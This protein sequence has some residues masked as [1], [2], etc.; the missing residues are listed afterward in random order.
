MVD[1]KKAHAATEPLSTPLREKTLEAWVKLS[2]LEQRGGG[3]LSVETLDGSVFDAIVFGEKDPGQWLAGSDFFR[4]TRSFGGPAETTAAREYVQLALV[5]HADGTIAGYR[6]G[7]PYGTAYRSGPPVEF[8]PGQY[9]VLFGLRHSPA[10]GNRLLAGTILRA[11]LYDRALSSDEV[12]A[13]AGVGTVTEAELLAH[14]TMEQRAERRKHQAEASRLAAD[15]A[16]LEAALVGK[17]YAVTAVEPGPTHLLLRG[18]VTA[19][20]PI[21]TPGGVAAVLH[22]AEL[23]LKPGS[24]EGERR[25][26]LAKWITSANNPLFARVIVNRLW[27]HHF[28]VGLVDTPSDFGFNGGRP[29]HPELLDFLADELVRSGWRLKAMHRLIV[30]SAAYRRSSRL[31][32]AALKVDAGNR[33][34]WRQ[35][36]RRLEAEAV[37]DTILA[38][39]GRLD[40]TVGGP[41]YQDFRSYFFKGTQFYDPIA[42][43]GPTFSRRTLYRTWARGGRNPFL[44]VF[45]CPDP[46]ATAP[47]RSTTTT[48][49]QALTLLNNAFVLD[50]ADHFADRLQREAGT[51]L[52]RQLNRAWLLAYGRSPD[53][54]EL[55]QPRRFVRKHGLAAFCRVVFNSNEFITVE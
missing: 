23:G 31:D 11:R 14:L 15:A 51:D 25:I 45:D 46:S 24:P 29:S 39:S 35:S 10:G 42:Q 40:R 7:K 19:K 12:A 2:G 6:N 36:P 38:V 4:R 49:L 28:G 9:H 1:G 47:R 20:G 34:L 48:P 5:Y 16:R 50:Q 26:A 21:V 43:V 53:Q 3:V 55:E 44:D 22:G 52:E 54:G 30:L 8:K 37:R 32:E 27:Q 41:G 18:E 17:V 13:S 33:L